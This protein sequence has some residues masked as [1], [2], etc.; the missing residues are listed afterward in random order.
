M[1]ILPVVRYPDP[2]LKRPADP[3]GEV[4]DELQRLVARGTLILDRMD[5]ASDVFPRKVHR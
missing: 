4:T 2:V 1:A 3:V 5:S